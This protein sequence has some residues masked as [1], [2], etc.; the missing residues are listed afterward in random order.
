MEIGI[1]LGGTKTE[2]VLLDATGAETAR[3]RRPTPQQQG[4]QAILEN[5]ASLVTDLEARSKTRC[6]IGVAAPGALDN[7]G[8]VKNSNTQCLIGQP[9]LQDLETLLSRPVRLENDANCFTLAEAVDGAGQ[10]AAS[11]FGVI[12]GTGVGG[13]IVVNGE[14]LPGLQHIAGEWGHNCLEQNGPL[15]YC[16]QHGCIETFLSGSGFSAD[17]QRLGGDP[18]L[19]PQEIVADAGRQN[20]IAQLALENLLERFGKAL[21]SVINIL[22]PH[23]VVLGGGLSN[24]DCLYTEGAQRVAAHVFNASLDTPIRRNQ[25]G[26]SAGVRGAAHLWHR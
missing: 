7:T 4:Y 1:D 10:N 22:D 15:C 5:I 3:Q 11:V 18:A 8:R 21:A 25:H 26:D 23:V 17:Y 12:M 24:I 14:L 19:S 6:S 13:G 20:A 9:L 2:G 16:G